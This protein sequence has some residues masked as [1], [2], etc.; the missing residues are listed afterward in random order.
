[1]PHHKTELMTTDRHFCFLSRGVLAVGFSRLF[2]LLALASFMAAGVSA[3]GQN[4]PAYVFT[5]FAG[6]T[7]TGFNDGTGSVA[8][9]NMPASVSLGSGSNLYVAD[10]A[11]HTI[12]KITAA[13]VVTTLAGGAGFYGTNNALGTAA[14]FYHPSGVA[15]DSATNVLV[16]DSDNHTIRNINAAGLVTVLAGK[17]GTSG[18]NDGSGSAAQFNHPMAVAVSGTTNVFVAD[19]DNHT[20]RKITSAGVV[21]TL[22]GAAGIPGAV[23]D[24]G[25]AARFNHPTG[26]A[27]DRQ[28]NVFVADNGNLT[29]RM[30]TPEGVVTT[31]AGLAGFYGT[32]DGTGSDAR[33]YD[34]VGVAMDAA[35]NLIVIESN[36][37]IRKVTLS[38]EVTTLTNG[39][40]VFNAPRGVAVVTAGNLYVADSLNNRIAKGILV[41]KKLP[42]FVFLA[43]DGQILRFSWLPDYLGWELQTA[44]NLAVGGLAPIWIPVPGSTNSTS[45]NLPMDPA[46]PMRF[47]RLHQ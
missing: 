17:A 32:R 10:F 1:M 34:P 45:L 21:T 28:G 13:G 36:N 3:L 14:R 43:S 23:D 15:V 4:S 39:L 41:L 5:N 27:V 47:Y 11:N 20:I 46:N 8:R 7:F 38:G 19:A 44:T 9:F 31:L 2:S 26:V 6:A 37:A 40:G 12:R 30:V 35:G 33:F 42:P 22:A 24:T 25:D 29:I 16:A 18:T